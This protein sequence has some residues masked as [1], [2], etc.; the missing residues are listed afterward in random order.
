[1][2]VTRSA[3]ASASDRMWLDSSTVRPARRSSAT[4]S[5]KTASISGSRPEVG[6]SSTSSSASL[7]SAATSATF[8]LLP[9]E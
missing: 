5:R 8:C 7:A 4:Q 9:L 6:S 1:M 2:I 3:S